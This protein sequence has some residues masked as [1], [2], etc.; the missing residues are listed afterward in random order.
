MYLEALVSNTEIANK[1]ASSHLFPEICPLIPIIK[2]TIGTINII[3]LISNFEIELTPFS[4]SVL[5]GL[6]LIFEQKT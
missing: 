6:A 4:K 2:K 5:I 1:N 3:I